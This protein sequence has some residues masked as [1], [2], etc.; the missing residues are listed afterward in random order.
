MGVVDSGQQKIADILVAIL[1]KEDVMGK[2]IKDILKM[3]SPSEDDDESAKISETLALMANA[4]DGLSETLG[5]VKASVDE[6]VKVARSG[7]LA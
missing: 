1:S 4:I 3:L 2:D 6:L 5:G 7:G